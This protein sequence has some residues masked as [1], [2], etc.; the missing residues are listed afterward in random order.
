MKKISII[1]IC[2]NSASTI[3]DTIKSVLAQ[4]YPEVEYIIVDGAS[5]DNTIEI[6]KRH[7]KGISTIISEPDQGIYDAMNKGVHAATGHVVGILNSDD[8]YADDKVLSEVMALFEKENCDAVY[9]DLKYVA[10]DNV[11]K[12]IRHWKSGE[13][14]SGAFIKGWMPPHPTFFLKKDCYRKFGNYS[15]ALRSAADYELML[16][17][18]HKHGISISYLH[19]V[20]TLMRVGGESNVT[21]KNRLRANREDQKAWEMNGLKPGLF[22]LLRKPLSKLIQFIR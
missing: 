11:S 8:V 18:I 10:R 13:Y 5:S 20:T 3:E 9:A 19:R 12:T 7:E 17:M 4:D 21:L 1:T 15:T 14:K 22:T 16:R 2:F 6:V